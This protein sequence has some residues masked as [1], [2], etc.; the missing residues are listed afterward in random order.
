MQAS[1]KA[2]LPPPLARPPTQAANGTH[3]YASRKSQLIPAA[4]QT[5]IRSAI[6]DARMNLL[7]TSGNARECR[8]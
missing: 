6:L 3:N 4:G 8:A 2:P 5:V 1:E 7:G